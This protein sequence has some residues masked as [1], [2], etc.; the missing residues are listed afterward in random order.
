MA[1]NLV[2]P[3]KRMAARRRIEAAIRSR[4]LWGQR[5]AGEHELAA[6]LGVSRK[7]VRAA[8]AELEMAGV[9]ERLVGSGTFVA[10]R[11]GKSA[12]GRRRRARLAVIAERHAEALP[13][14]TFAGEILRG[15]LA[16]GLRLRAECQILALDVPEE[17]DRL[18]D[19]RQLRR[20][21]GFISVGAGSRELLARLIELRRGPV[22]LLD[23]SVR[24][25]PVVTVNDG[26]FAGSRAV[27]RHLIGLGHRRIAFLNC[28]H[29]AENNPEKLAGYRAALTE[30]G[31]LVDARLV[32]ERPAANE[33]GHLETFAD[34]AVEHL[35][36]LPDAPTAILGFDDGFAL[37]AVRALERRGLRVG[38]DLSVA[39]Q[40][41]SA[42]RQGTCDWLTS[43]RTYPDKIGAEAVRAALARGPL[44]EGRT[45]IVSN[46][47]CVRRSTCPPPAGG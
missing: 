8:L 22:V 15:V 25:L 42:I 31:L 7:T 12:D 13:E 43:T 37:P 14:W 26:S 4:S 30:K 5:L 41:D 40:G 16:C 6:Q 45:V 36:G 1:R 38:Q 47:L 27:T 32:L 34:R 23:D 2:Q 29:P 33:G 11:P 18:K 10:E 3:H 20:F 17:R 21:R 9:V 28:H 35:L 19:R 44:T 46:R 39:G 24:D